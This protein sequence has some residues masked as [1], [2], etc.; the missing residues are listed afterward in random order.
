MSLQP[1]D[2]FIRDDAPRADAAIV[3]GCSDTEELQQRTIAASALLASGKTG[4]LLL[5]AGG[6]SQSEDNEAD[7]MTAIAVRAGAE[8]RQLIAVSASGELSETARDCSKLFRTDVR[9]SGLRS[10]WLVSSA[11]HMLRLRIVM[12]HHLPRQLRLL[13]HPTEAGITAANWMKQPRGRALA[14]N[15]IRLIEKLLKNGY[16][17]K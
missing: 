10:V 13:C 12:K 16:S 1:K 14:E 17:L 5:C 11:W 15:E 3:C 9:L 6:R 8:A 4:L 2:L 7:R